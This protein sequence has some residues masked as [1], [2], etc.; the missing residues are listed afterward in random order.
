MQSCLRYRLRMAKN[1]RPEPSR[2]KPLEILAD[3]LAGYEQIAPSGPETCRKYLERVLSENKSLP[4]ASKFFVYDLLAEAYAAG[5]DATGATDAIRLAQ[6]YLPEA[7][8]EAPKHY[9]AYRSRIR[10]FERGIAL[11]VADGRLKDALR[12][13]DDATALGLGNFY[14]AKAESIRGRLEREETVG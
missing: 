11:C 3:L 9:Q 13:C 10:L 7:Q 4:N 12:F 14:E 1:R 5:Q 8:A 6:Q 2:K